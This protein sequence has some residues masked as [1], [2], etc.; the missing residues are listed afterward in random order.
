MYY[1]DEFMKT[2]PSIRE[3]VR[4]LKVDLTTESVIRK[5][6]KEKKNLFHSFSFKHHKEYEEQKYKDDEI[7]K[8][9]DTI[10]PTFWKGIKA[11]NLT[12]KEEIFFEK[13]EDIKDFFNLKH[14]PIRAI[15]KKINNY[16]GYKWQEL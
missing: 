13:I 7:L 3:C 8:F 1:K 9:K 11:I 15:R 2:F 10:K 6:L 5:I 4:F 14:P 12:T 16:R